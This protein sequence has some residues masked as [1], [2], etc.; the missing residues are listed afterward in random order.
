[1]GRRTSDNLL[2]K[3]PPR[4][5]HGCTR[6]YGEKGGGGGGENS[7]K[8]N[9]HPRRLSPEFLR[10]R[11]G[12]CGAAGICVGPEFSIFCPV[13]CTVAAWLNHWSVFRQKENLSPHS[14]FPFS[15]YF[16]D[17]L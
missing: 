17:F 12:G 6:K 1:M 15:Q 11:L 10:G 8:S 3:F 16:L 7:H 4:A 2:L 13:Y 5:T 14:A 9:P